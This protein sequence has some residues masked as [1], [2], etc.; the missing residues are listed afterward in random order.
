MMNAMPFVLV[1]L[2]VKVASTNKREGPPICRPP[3]R[4]ANQQ[5]HLA[6]FFDRSMVQ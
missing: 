6:W 5:H 2:I 1:F 4:D 3:A